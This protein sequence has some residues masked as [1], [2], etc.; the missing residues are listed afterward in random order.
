MKG[1]EYRL[2]YYTESYCKKTLEAAKHV[3][4]VAEKFLN[5]TKERI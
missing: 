3:Y 4:S 5:E 1:K 2:H